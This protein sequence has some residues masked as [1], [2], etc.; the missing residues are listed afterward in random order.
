LKPG[1]VANRRP[2][3]ARGDTDEEIEDLTRAQLEERDGEGSTPDPPPL[4]GDWRQ[5]IVDIR[6]PNLMALVES[7]RMDARLRRQKDVGLVHSA[8]QKNPPAVHVEDRLPFYGWTMSTCLRERME[9][10]ESRAYANDASRLQLPRE[11]LHGL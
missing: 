4:E 6:T 2:L 8:H 9:K 10:D 5:S 7:I 11:G 3:P 1:G